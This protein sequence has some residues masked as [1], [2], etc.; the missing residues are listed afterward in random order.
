[1]LAYGSENW[2]MS[3]SEGRKTETPEMPFFKACLWIYDYRPFTQYNTQ[4]IT[5][6]LQKK[7]P[8]NT[9]NK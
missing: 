6:M 4:R 3:R 8:K 9:K 5:N 7:V 1:M 2:A